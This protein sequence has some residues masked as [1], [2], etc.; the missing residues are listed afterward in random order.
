MRFVALW[1]MPH[2]VKKSVGGTLVRK[3]VVF[4]SH[5]EVKFLH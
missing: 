4:E 5:V 1:N 2:S 3:N